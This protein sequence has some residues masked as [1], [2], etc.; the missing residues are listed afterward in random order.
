[1]ASASCGHCHSLV[2]TKDGTVYSFGRNAYGQLGLGDAEKQETG[3]EAFPSKYTP[4]KITWFSEKLAKDD[5]VIQVYAGSQHSACV[6]SKGN[7]AL[8]DFDLTPT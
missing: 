5:K 8:K 2:L 1:M 4:Q 7:S 6:T 3:V